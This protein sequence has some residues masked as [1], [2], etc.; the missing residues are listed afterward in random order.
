MS[1]HIQRHILNIDQPNTQAMRMM[2]AVLEFLRSRQ[3]DQRVAWDGKCEPGDFTLWN[4]VSTN[5][6]TAVFT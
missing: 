5:K 2:L 1:G 3:L 4:K 6:G